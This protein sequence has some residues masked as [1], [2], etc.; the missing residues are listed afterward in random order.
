MDIRE[1]LQTKRQELI[2]RHAAMMQEAQAA[3]QQVV[4]LAGAVAVVDLMGAAF[5]D[6][7]AE[8]EPTEAE[9]D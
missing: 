1:T 7:P 5:P 2:G 9:P 8:S 4:A 3:Q 6:D